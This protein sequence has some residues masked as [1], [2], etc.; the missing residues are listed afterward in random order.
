[1]TRRVFGVIG[2]LIGFRMEPRR[3][4]IEKV[5]FEISVPQENQTNIMSTCQ[6]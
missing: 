6:L 1:M 2:A 5:D 3:V 4:G